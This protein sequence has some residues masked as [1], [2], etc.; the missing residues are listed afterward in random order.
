MRWL[1]LLVGHAGKPFGMLHALV[2]QYVQPFF[3]SLAKGSGAA[4]KESIKPATKAINELETLLSHL[5]QDTDIPQIE[6]VPEKAI[7]AAVSQVE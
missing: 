1:P 3:G 5:Q 2:Q 6:I 7:A 4:D